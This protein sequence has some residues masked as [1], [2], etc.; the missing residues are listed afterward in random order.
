MADSFFCLDIH[1][2]RIAAV[3]VDRS[4]AVSI[5]TGCGSADIV[6]QSFEAA[7]DQI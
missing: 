1:R 6:E 4:S 5:V 2:D 3:V 7:L